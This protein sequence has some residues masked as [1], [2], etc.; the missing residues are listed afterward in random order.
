MK[1]K[2]IGLYMASFGINHAVDSLVMKSV[3]I[4]EDMGATVIK[5]DKISPPDTAQNSFQ[6]MLYEYKDGLNKYFSSLGEDAPLKNLEELI[7]FNK[8][9]SIELK[10]FIFPSLSSQ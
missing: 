2:R 10:Y 3:S 6:V 4:L 7:K 9:D 1:K 5:I 8:Q